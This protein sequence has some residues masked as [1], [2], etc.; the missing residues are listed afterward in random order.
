M[1]MGFEVLELTFD[2]RH[3]AGCGE[4]FPVG[5]RF[6]RSA[7]IAGHS[8]RFWT[9]TLGRRSINSLGF[10]REAGY[11][12]RQ[13]RFSQGAIATHLPHLANPF[14]FDGT[15]LAIIET[16]NFRFRKISVFVD[17]TAG[18]ENVAVGIA[19]IA[20]GIRMMETYAKG[21]AV[22]IAQLKAESPQQIPLRPRI[23][24][25]GQSHVH[26][27][28]HASVPTPFGLFGTG[29][30]FARR[31]LRSDDLPLD[32]I[33]LV[34]GPVVLLARAIV[35]QFASRV[36]GDLGN[37]TVPFGPADRADREMKDRHIMSEAF[38]LLGKKNRCP[39]SGSEPSPTKAETHE[40]RGE[41]PAMRKC[42]SP[43]LQGSG[44]LAMF[45]PK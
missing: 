10:Q 30:Q 15:K 12:F 35:G 39:A 7:A 29:G 11:V 31:H 8:D 18:H 36:V 3:A 44:S 21:R 33:L 43:F 40:H 28:A 23:Q 26:R 1:G 4:D 16:A 25:M 19:L 45:F 20:L 9:E 17:N 32:H 22:F 14:D 41:T 38:G 37:G 6:P 42:A 5:L 2:L 27:P 34:F 24:L 13:S